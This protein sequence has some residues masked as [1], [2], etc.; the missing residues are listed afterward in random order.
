MVVHME[1]IK[2]NQTVR[3]NEEAFHH[4]NKGNQEKWPAS[5]SFNFNKY[6]VMLLSQQWFLYGTFAG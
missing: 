4:I 2:T 5:V 1:R 3:L 6:N